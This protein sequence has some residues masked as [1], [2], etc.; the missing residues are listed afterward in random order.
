[1]ADGSGNAISVV[2]L[3][4]FPGLNDSASPSTGCSSL[5]FGTATADNGI[6]IGHV[7]NWTI[8]NVEIAGYDDGLLIGPT[9]VNVTV[10]SIVCHDVNHH[11]VYFD[12]GSPYANYEGQG[13]AGGD[14]NFSTD[15]AAF[16]A[17]TVFGCSFSGLATLQQSGNSTEPS[18]VTVTEVDSGSLSY[19]TEL[20]GTS[21]GTSPPAFVDGQ[22]SGTTGGLGVY[23][24]YN[25]QATVSTPESITG[26]PLACQS[27][28]ACGASYNAKVLNSA[29]YGNGNG[30]YEPLH[31]NDLMNGVV[32]ANNR[33]SFNGGNCLAMQTGVYNAWIENNLCFDNARDNVEMVIGQ[34]D[35]S[36]TLNWNAIRNNIFWSGN[37]ANE[38]RGAGGAFGGINQSMSYGT[39]GPYAIPGSHYIKNTT[40]TGNKFVGYYNA[41]TGN[42]ALEFGSIS[43]PIAIDA[44]P[45]T[46]TV[47]N[48]LLWST[49]SGNPTSYAMTIAPNA[50]ATWVNGTYPFSGGSA[51]NLTTVE[52]FSQCYPSGNNTFGAP[53]FVTSDSAMLAD[54]L[55]PGLY[56]FGPYYLR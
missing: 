13:A 32:V 11:C 4:Y 40:I 43:S 24:V 21:L 26:A 47:S 7:A 18:T 6:K 37:P 15:L 48:N 9:S 28:P 19:G 46:D 3:S 35:V 30:G 36:S 20:T 22:I 2:S 34:S 52:S 56:D 1:M 25:V 49:Y 41:S 29:M 14:F 17:N 23:V 51:C 42:A 44:Y 31:I 16:R 38:I 53:G 39:N 33:F 8:K 55:N 45:E 5:A 27:I 10:D 50:S 12:Y 54:W